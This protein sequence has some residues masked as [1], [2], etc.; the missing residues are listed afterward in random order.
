[1]QQTFMEQAVCARPCVG[2]WGTG[3]VPAHKLLLILWF[4]S[5]GY[6]ERETYQQLFMFAWLR[7]GLCPW[8]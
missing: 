3:M 8:T 4:H 2:H 1:M 6:L 5:Q 7:H